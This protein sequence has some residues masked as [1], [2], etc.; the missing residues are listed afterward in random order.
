MNSPKKKHY[1]GRKIWFTTAIVLSSLILLLS[2][3]GVFGT[4]AVEQAMAR[5]SINL[6]RAVDTAA[7]ATRLVIER[8]DTRVNQVSSIAST[9]S[10]TSALISKNVEDKGLVLSL[11]PPEKEAE[12]TGLLGSLAESFNNIR[13]AVKGGINLY[14]SIDSMPF[15]NLPMPGE[16][17]IQEMQTNMN[18]IETKVAELRQA[19]QDFRSGVTGKIDMVTQLADEINILLGNFTQDLAKLDSDLATVQET[20]VELQVIIPNILALAAFIVTLFLAFVVYTQ[21]EMVA[22]YVRRWQRLGS[23]EAV[24][25][26]GPVEIETSEVV[27]QSAVVEQPAVKEQPAVVDQQVVEQPGETANPPENSEGA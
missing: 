5:F 11:L 13:D 19:V 17:R 15:I 7:G 24:Q 16:D 8:V 1:I 2:V 20:A 25:L 26:E 9:V 12:L 21:V 6:L 14:K 10:D 23:G 4:W 3:A 27:E 18:A 22:L